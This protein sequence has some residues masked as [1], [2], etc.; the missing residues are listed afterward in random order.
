MG[1]VHGVAGFS[2]NAVAALRR[3]RP[4]RR[5]DPTGRATLLLKEAGLHQR[6][7]EYVT[8][9]RLLAHAR[10]A[11]RDVEGPLADSV[12]SRLATRYSFG[13]YLQHD[14]SGALRWSETG[15]REARASGDDDALAYAYNTRH[16]AC[17]HAGVA[18]E[19][20][21][22][23]LALAAY[24]S[25]GDLRMQ[26]HCLNNLAIGAMQ[27]GVWD[28]SAELLDRAAGMFR[29][30]GDTANEANALYNRADLLIRQRRFAAAEPLLQAA[31]RAATAADDRELVALATREY[32]RA[33]AGG[34]GN[35]DAVTAFDT[36]RVIFAERG[37]AEELS[38]LDE[39]VAEH[40]LAAGDFDAAID[41]AGS[42]IARAGE[43]H[44]DS[45]LGALYR[46]RGSALL[47]AGRYADAR[48]AFTAGLNS[49][50]GGDGRREYAFNLLGLAE[51]A[52]R[53]G[54]GEGGAA[55]GGAGARQ[56]GLG[57]VAR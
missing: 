52:A 40:L 30:I 55:V 18:E 15:V 50:D 3:A 24:E 14:Y 57:V 11:L 39:A 12:R 2:R 7:G 42:A 54:A 43:L 56:G 53:T 44:H 48:A 34:A 27:D 33:R 19:E 1:D 10:G 32:G 6:L 26:A 45:A 29:R 22:G 28:R 36:A 38:T 25:T 13:K 16:T 35:D 9:L 31:M 49:P 21:Y 17:F 46:V 41:Q 8:S 47:S 51:V 20:P 37:L 4:Y 23:E 5:D